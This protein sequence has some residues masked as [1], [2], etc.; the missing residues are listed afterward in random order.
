MIFAHKIYECDNRV[1]HSYELI[2]IYPEILQSLN[3]LM[4]NITD[5]TIMHAKK[6]L[7][8][9]LGI[10]QYTIAKCSNTFRHRHSDG[11]VQ[12]TLKNGNSKQNI[13]FFPYI[14]AL[15]KIH[16]HL[17][18][19]K[20]SSLFIQVY[21]SIE[22]MYIN[23][24]PHCLYFILLSDIF[25]PTQSNKNNKRNKPTINSKNNCV[26]QQEKYDENAMK[27]TVLATFNNNQTQLKERLLQL[28][29][30]Q[31]SSINSSLIPIYI[32]LAIRLLSPTAQDWDRLWQQKHLCN[33][34]APLYNLYIIHM[35]TYYI[36]EK[37]F[38]VNPQQISKIE[39]ML[40]H[41]HEV[42]TEL[43][44]NKSTDDNNYR[45]IVCSFFSV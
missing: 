36:Y 7:L 5:N 28:L 3:T 31:D 12:V 30:S 41:F 22:A 43:L 17:A 6:Q 19:S 35:L 24:P 10:F 4:R 44:S 39:Y 1:A 2:H 8:L 25:N 20:K 9:L 18:S 11:D 29:Q 37:N 33:K 38:T 14:T 45:I 34:K 21:H 42:S 23:I 26:I 32:W 13:G 27:G 40:K 16:S 15:R